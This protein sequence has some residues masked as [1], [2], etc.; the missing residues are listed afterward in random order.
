M[1]NSIFDSWAAMF[2]QLFPGKPY[3]GRGISG[4]TTPQMLVR[5]RQDV[6]ALKPAVVV[7]LAGTNDIA[8]NTGPATDAMIEGN[9]AGM[10]EL[11]HANGIRVVL[12]SI[13][14]VHR[15]PWRPALDPA[16]RIIT[17]NAWIRDYAARHGDVFL[18]YHSRM[19]DERQGMRAELTRDGVHPNEAGYRVMAP[20]TERAI[21]EALRRAPRIS[22][23]DVRGTDHLVVAQSLSHGTVHRDIVHSAALGVDKHVNV[24][25]PA[26]YDR[27]R[28]RRYPVAIY[29]HGLFGSENDW[30]G[31]G[32]LAETAD[33]LAVAGAGEA[34]IVTPD[35]DDGWWTSWAEESSYESCADTLHSEAPGSYCVRSHRYDDWITRD[36]VSAIAARYRTYDDRVHRGIAGLSMG[37]F[38]ALSLALRNPELFAAAASHSGVVSMLYA[39]A[40]P[41]APPAR[42]VPTSD[43]LRASPMSFKPRLTAAFGADIASWRDHDP[44]TLAE[45]VKASGSAMPALFLDCGREDSLLDENRALDWELTRLGI[46]HDYSEWPGAHTWR[47][48]HDHSAQSLSWML[49]RIGAR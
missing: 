2:P 3:I 14:P 41:F 15:Y 31:K 48:W 25:L 19:A 36:L 40:H 16:L 21:A 38:G 1:G 34:I 33:S 12:A 35:G 43:S 44:A 9:I 8:E 18:D 29:L 23:P 20:L 11:A 22:A 7:I 10:S 5:F 17:L 4:Q 42:Y 13:L 37:G 30:M 24:Y 26:S 47:Y 45:R 6:V 46:P 39:G 32:G 27:D 49:G 28:S